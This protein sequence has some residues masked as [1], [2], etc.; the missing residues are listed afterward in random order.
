M[1]AVPS[2]HVDAQEMKKHQAPHDIRVDDA[3]WD[4]FLQST[5]LGQFQQSSSWARVKALEG[6][7]AE[8]LVW[9]TPDAVAGGAQILWKRTR[10]G[11]IGFVNKGPVLLPESSREVQ[12][13]VARIR[14]AGRRLQLSALILQAPDASTISDQQLR[15]NGFFGWPFAGII[16]A[17]A[18]LDVSGGREA[19]LARMNRR[20]R[21]ELRQ[22]FKRGVTIVEGGRADLPLFFELML[23]SC[24]RQQ[25]QASPARV[26]SFQQ[27]WDEFHP[28]ARLGFARVGEEAVAGLFMLGFGD[29]FTFW[30]KGWN[31]QALEAHANTCLNVECLGWAFDGGYRHVDFGALDST[32]AESLLAG[33]AL[34]EAQQR[35][36]HVF[37]LRLGAQPK[38]LPK[39]YF[40][41]FSPV[42]RTALRC[43]LGR[44]LQ[45][46]LARK[47]IRC[48]A[49]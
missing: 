44:L 45:S 37:N 3:V 21:Q 30:K 49:R 33:Q 26:E 47:L 39:A 34:T 12:G 17:T 19:I 48:A 7:H 31:S 11:R 40:H 29:R 2:N 38:L 5:P 43:G 36:R 25:T 6:W 28:S 15:Q 42:L 20:T 46:P 8:R 23:C 4:A 22:A 16:D 41:V 1:A 18:L 9:G 10:L 14:V 32:I 27:I 24:R 35:T 13:A